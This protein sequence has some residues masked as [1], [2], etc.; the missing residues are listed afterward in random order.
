MKQILCDDLFPRR[1]TLVS[2]DK[3]LFDSFK[4]MIL[5]RSFQLYEVDKNEVVISNR[6]A[7]ETA[8][9]LTVRANELIRNDPYFD[10][11]LLLQQLDIQQIIIGSLNNVAS[12]VG[13]SP[14]ARQYE[15]HRKAA[16]G[17]SLSFI[18]NEFGTFNEAK[19]FAGLEERP[20]GKNQKYI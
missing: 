16:G 12:I 6:Y 2:V 18:K 7:V 13:H 20:R 19:R 8:L 3:A 14:T 4:R 9:W 10:D 5:E 11:E 17:P 15:K 1:K